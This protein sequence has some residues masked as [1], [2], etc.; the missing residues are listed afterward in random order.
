MDISIKIIR[1]QMIIEEIKAEDFSIISLDL[2]ETFN[3]ILNIG[4]IN[5][6]ITSN[7]S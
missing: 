5:V 4:K 7:V 1:V 6:S 2:D 3:L